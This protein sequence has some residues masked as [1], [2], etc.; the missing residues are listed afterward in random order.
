MDMARLLAADHAAAFEH[1]LQHVA[2]AH[3]G[4]IHLNAGF[5]HGFME[6]NIAHDGRR[7]LVLRQ[8][9][10]LF[11]HAGTDGDYAVSV[12]HLS[13]FVGYDQTVGVAVKRPCRCKRLHV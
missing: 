3:A 1:L 2:V 12:D 5:L 9:S 8:P 10:L 6:T 11:E 4:H 7:H 13:V